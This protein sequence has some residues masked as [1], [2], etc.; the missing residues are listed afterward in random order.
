MCMDK[1]HTRKTCWCRVQ[2]AVRQQCA[3]KRELRFAC[4]LA[5]PDACRSNT[6]LAEENYRARALHMCGSGGLMLLSEPSPK[7][8][9]AGPRRR[10]GGGHHAIRVGVP[11]LTPKTQT[12][13][14]E[15]GTAQ[16]EKWEVGGAGKGTEPAIAFAWVGVELL[17]TFILSF[18]IWITCRQDWH[19][20]R[21]PPSHTGH[22]GCAWWCDG[23]TD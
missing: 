20:Q 10:P 7:V 14:A 17:R 23:L 6:G 8:A 22:A 13:L 18:P 3:S 19:S 12:R 21:L 11:E 2:R 5:M 9:A 1:G 16:G 4:R 15:A